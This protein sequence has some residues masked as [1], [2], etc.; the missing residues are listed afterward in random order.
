MPLTLDK[1]GKLKITHAQVERACIQL[2]RAEHW[3]VFQTHTDA[4]Q[5][6]GEKGQVDLVAVRGFNALGWMWLERGNPPLNLPGVSATVLFI[7]VKA[8]GEKPSKI[9]KAWHTAAE[10]DGF[11][12]LVVSE[13]TD[14]RRYLRGE[15]AS[16]VQHGER[17]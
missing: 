9:Q 8:P 5:S 3:R 6:M 17:G 10:L 15:Q 16:D 11:E 1:R 4:R 12:V 13:V 2:L 14:L 7:E